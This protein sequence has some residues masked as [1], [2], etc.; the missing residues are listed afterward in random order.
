MAAW[1][2]ILLLAATVALPGPP[3]IAWT[4]TA[5]SGEVRV[6]GLPADELAAANVASLDQLAARL[7]VKVVEGGKGASTDVLPQLWGSFA[8]EPDCLVFRPRHRPAAGMVLVARYLAAGREPLLLRHEF[9]PPPGQTRVI[10]VHPAATEIPENLLRFY[11]VFS[12]PMSIK[13]IAEQVRLRDGRGREIPGAFVSIP[14]GLWDPEIRRLTLI[15]HPGR[16]KSGIAVGEV[17]GRVLEAGR[18]V[19]LEIDGA[20]RDSFG[21][22]LGETYRQTFRVGPAQSAALAASGLRLEIR[23]EGEKDPLVIDFPVVVD[24]ALAAAALAVE[25]QGRE[26]AGLFEL[27]AGDRQLLFY[28]REPWQR[29]REHILKIGEIFEDVAGNRFGRAFEGNLES[30][31]AAPAERSFYP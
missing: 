4:E 27:A 10:A 19:T 28:P 1:P 13:G 7:E 6:C 11:V 21:A 2:L 22:N 17:E 12:A 5:S 15:V 9:D 25:S 26:I 23:D 14:D 18:E 31:P 8:T 24:F 20:A 29:G 3:T 30:A 16:V